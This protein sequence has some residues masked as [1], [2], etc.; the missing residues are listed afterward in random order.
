M[1]SWK[2]WAIYRSKPA[3]VGVRFMGI[4]A[5]I[6]ESGQLSYCHIVDH[7]RPLIILFEM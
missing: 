4:V 1:V 2:I 3:V 5:A 6:I 7:N